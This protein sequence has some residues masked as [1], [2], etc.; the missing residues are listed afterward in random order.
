MADMA[1]A[2]AQAGV[3]HH[4][5]HYRNPG[6]PDLDKLPGYVIPNVWNSG[7][8]RGGGQNVGF[9]DDHVSW[10]DNPFCG[11]NGDNIYTTDPGANVNNRQATRAVQVVGGMAHIAR[12]WRAGKTGSYDTVMLPAQNITDRKQDQGF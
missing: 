8:H 4:R 12:S 6:M 7:N 10:H 9:G 2:L 1:P 11:D 5:S 3:N